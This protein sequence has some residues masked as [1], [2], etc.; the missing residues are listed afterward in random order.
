MKRRITIAGIGL[1]LALVAVPAVAI[2]QDSD[3]APAHPTEC[4]YHAEH[5]GM[6][7]QMG[8]GAAMH[9]AGMADHAVV[10]GSMMGTGG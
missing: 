2:A 1:A 10:H 8:S 5:A 7:H 9:G 4:P 3:P 6:S